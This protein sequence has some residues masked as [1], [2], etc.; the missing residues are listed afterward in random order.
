MSDS[1]KNEGNVTELRPGDLNMVPQHTVIEPDAVL[2]GNLERFTHV[3]VIG[4]DKTDGSLALCCSHSSENA[5]WLLD[6]A[7]KVLHDL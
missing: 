6:R 2:A 4:V 1:R 7:K 3:V 5:N